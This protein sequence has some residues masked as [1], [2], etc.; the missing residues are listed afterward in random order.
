METSL[1]GVGLF[2]SRQELSYNLGAIMTPSDWAALAVSV[3]TLVGALAM[4]VKH[5]TKHYLSELK[6]NGGSSLKDT[7]N[8]LEHKVELLTELVKEALRK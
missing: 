6:P 3:T 4:G 2:K 7:V 1:G 5:L 8:A